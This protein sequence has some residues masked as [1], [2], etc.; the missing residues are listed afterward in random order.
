MRF[1]AILKAIVN[2]NGSP[3]GIADI[4][5]AITVR[6][7]VFELYPLAYKA[8]VEIIEIIKIMILI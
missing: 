2:A 1:E 6:N 5:S 8:K 4:D 7:I 3:S